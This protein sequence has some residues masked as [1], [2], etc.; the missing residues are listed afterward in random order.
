MNEGD[1]PEDGHAELNRDRQFGGW[2]AVRRLQSEITKNLARCLIHQAKQNSES[3]VVDEAAADERR[4]TISERRHP[5]LR[6][7]RILSAVLVIMK[8]N[9][10]VILQVGID[11]V[12]SDERERLRRHRS[13]KRSPMHQNRIDQ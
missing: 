3:D 4:R 12:N 1:A 8:P 5:C 13:E 11:R 10:S 2:Y 7:E 6:V 9:Q